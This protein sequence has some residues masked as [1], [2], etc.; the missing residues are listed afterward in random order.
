MNQATIDRLA[1]QLVQQKEAVLKRALSFAFETQ[2]EPP[3]LTELQ[4]RL[5]CRVVGGETEVWTLD[6]KLLATIYKP[7]YSGSGDRMRVHLQ[8]KI[9]NEP[10][11]EA[12]PETGEV[13]RHGTR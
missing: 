1:R 8:Y 5:C 13:I 10:E 2:P 12:L 9:E 4:G 6:G 11:P 3:G 7:T